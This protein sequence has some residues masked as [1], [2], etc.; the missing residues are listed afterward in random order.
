MGE[1]IGVPMGEIVGCATGEAVGVTMDDSESD[2][3]GG[4]TGSV[5]SPSS[6]R[7][8]GGS[9]TSET[10]LQVAETAVIAGNPVSL[11][12]GFF[13]TVVWGRECA[14]RTACI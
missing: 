5:M 13:R 10:G 9:E 3:I 12:P 1:V 14:P 2:T 8:K 4:T 11:S 7:A 6:L